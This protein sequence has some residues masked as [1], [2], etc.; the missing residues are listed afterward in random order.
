MPKIIDG[1][2]LNYLQNK[3]KDNYAN[4]DGDLH[5]QEKTAISSNVI[6]EITP[7]ENYNGLKKVI[8][9]RL[10]AENITVKSTTTQQI[11]QPTAGKDLIK[12]VTI[13]PYTMQEKNVIVGNDTVTVIPDSE[14]DCLSKVMAEFKTQEKT[15]E[16]NHRTQEIIPDEN[17]HGL[18]KI[19]ISPY[20]KVADLLAGNNVIITDD[21]LPS[22]MTELT[23]DLNLHDALDPSSRTGEKIA[24]TLQSTQL[25]KINL[26]RYDKVAL[27][28]C[29][30]INAPNADIV[31]IN[32]VTNWGTGTMA[33]PKVKEIIGKSLTTTKC[34]FFVNGNGYPLRLIPPLNNVEKMAFEGCSWLNNVI[35][36]ENVTTIGDWAF[37]NCT[38]LTNITL[39]DNLTTIGEDAFFWCTSLTDITLPDSVTSIGEYAFGSCTSLTNISLPDSLTTIGYGAFRNCTSLT[40]ISLPDNITT[41]GEYAFG[42]CTK[43]TDISLPDNI[44]TIGEDTFNYCQKLQTITV[45]G[46]SSC[47]TAQT[48]QAMHPSQYNRATIVYTE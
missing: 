30:N 2:V 3:I 43:L 27:N 39:P 29:I 17:I 36:N 33:H 14:Y 5:L 26:V 32:D 22:D 40:N 16:Y 47:T 7:D 25:V 6:Q 35:I 20:M 15:A 8:V 21:D 34:C 18:E 12:Q 10:E 48:L 45:R 44:T 42:N 46:N 13:Q 19:V 4:K 11:I 31:C 24:L 28:G 9:P 23:L 38:S 37:A 41:I 1:D